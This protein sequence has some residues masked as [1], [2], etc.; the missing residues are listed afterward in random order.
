MPV[1]GEARLQ[2]GRLRLHHLH[3]QLRPADRRGLRRRQ[4][5]RPRRR[6]GAVRQ[7]QLRGPD[8]PRREDELPGL[9]A[10]GRRLRA[11]RHDG[12]RPRRRP[13]GPGRATATTSSS[14]DIWPTPPEVERGDRQ[15]RSPRRCSPTT[16]PTSSPATSAG[17]R[18]RRPRATPSPGTR[19]RPT[20][21]SPRTSTACRASR[22]RSPTSRAPACWPSSATRSPPT[23]SARPA[24]SRPDSPA[25]HVPRRA[26]R[27]AQ[28]LQLLR[29]APRQ[30]RGDDPRHVRQHPAAQPARSTASRAASPAT[31]PADGE[32][33][34]DLRR[35][36][37]HYQAAGTPLVVL[38]GKEY[39]SGSSR[40]W[41][42]K[43]TA[44]LGVKAV[45][46]ES[47]ERIHRSNLIGMGVLPLQFPAGPERR[48]RSGS[49]ARRRSSITG[50]TALNE[51]T[52][53]R[54]VTVTATRD[55][56][57]PSSST[58]WSASTPPARRTTTATA[59]SC[60]TSCGRSSPAEPLRG[61]GRG[62][63]VA[64]ATGPAR[65]PRLRRPS[66]TCRGTGGVGGGRHTGG[67]TDRAVRRR[68][69]PSRGPA[70]GQPRL[71]GAGD[72]A[73]CSTTA[74]PTT[75]ATRGGASTRSRSRG[76]PP[77]TSRPSS[78]P[79]A[80]AYRDVRVD[81]GELVPAEALPEI[82]ADLEAEGLRLRASARSAGL[83]CTTPCR[84]VAT[85]PACEAGGSRARPTP[86]ASDGTHACRH[87][88][89]A[90]WT[91]AP[92]PLRP[93]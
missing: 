18:C 20:S 36:A 63:P 26:R 83:V 27:R 72:R 66:G 62:G 16:T 4:R 50:V 55:D 58:P 42:A 89:G 74:R 19:S 56:G 49:T 34:H 44:L 45:I 30:P 8:Q 9:A 17:S 82:L 60:S 87:R 84:A 13:A 75:A 21:A 48:R 23:T 40:D 61:Q 14:K 71:A 88:R 85:S 59:A 79:C 77:G 57:E 65:D 39:G 53:P 92:T 7:P 24:R 78:R 43:G 35:V 51:G 29:L 3:R 28:G 10:A 46:A 93:P 41:A 70:A 52:T 11:R 31:S 6:L 5:E 2:P 91:P 1:P 68:G 37:Q 38:A 15:A 32:Q 73:G 64:A 90:A 81:L 12:L 67:V 47:Y 86:T 33:A 80:A 54:T 69:G 22:R 76:S 25:G